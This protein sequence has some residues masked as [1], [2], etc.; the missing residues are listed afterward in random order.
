M[1]RCSQR[2]AYT[3]RSPVSG[4]SAPHPQ[5]HDGRRGAAERAAQAV[6]RRTRMAA[7]DE[8]LRRA[9]QVKRPPRSSGR[10]SLLA[11]CPPFLLLLV[12]SIRF[13]NFVPTYCHSL[14]TPP[15]PSA[16]D[17]LLSSACLGRVPGLHRGSANGDS[18]PSE[19][20]VRR[21]GQGKEGRP[22]IRGA[23]APRAGAVCQRGAAARRPR[24][25][26]ALPEQRR[27]PGP[28]S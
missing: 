6:D 19:P 24:C 7:E 8:V 3:V 18:H 10:L 17:L 22:G 12:N 13:W 23:V 27:R 28:V 20:A 11:G 16:S 4:A 2:E 15:R 21:R 1:H 14:P 5:R 26:L 25:I 9:I